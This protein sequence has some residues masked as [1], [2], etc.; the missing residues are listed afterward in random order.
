MNENDYKRIVSNFTPDEAMQGRIRQSILSTAAGRRRWSRPAKI[1]TAA[2]SAIVLVIA[3]VFVFPLLQNA[4]PGVQP[5]TGDTVSSQMPAA[6]PP[7][8]GFSGFALT[9]FAAN[10]SYEVLTPDYASKATPTILAPGVEILMPEYSP[11]QS[12]VPGFP[13]IVDCKQ[14]NGHSVPADTIDLNASAGQLVT[15]NA[16]SGKVTDKGSMAS[17]SPGS[18]IY[19]SPVTGNSLT[20][21]CTTIRI[22]AMIKDKTQLGSQR[23]IGFQKITIREV[24]AAKYAIALQ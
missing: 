8:P 9:A 17:C 21:G 24:A 11:L 15:W 18:I 13:L 14:S 3:A 10:G 5:K 6:V 16:A 20:T 12:S 23:V 4:G 19:W 2:A 7:G 1:I 22:T